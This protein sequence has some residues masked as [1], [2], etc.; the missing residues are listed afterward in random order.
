MAIRVIQKGKI[1]C[2]KCG[3]ELAKIKASKQIFEALIEDGERFCTIECV[4]C[5]T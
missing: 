5:L 3:K 1:E 4:S 2:D